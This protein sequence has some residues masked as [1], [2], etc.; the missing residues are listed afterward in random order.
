LASLVAMA[1]VRSVPSASTR[2]PGWATWRCLSTMALCSGCHLMPA[3]LTEQWKCGA[4][5]DH[6]CRWRRFRYPKC[7]RPLDKRRRLAGTWHHLL[8]QWRWW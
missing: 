5:A 4:R 6:S 1:G 3:Q 8:H 2:T 7:A